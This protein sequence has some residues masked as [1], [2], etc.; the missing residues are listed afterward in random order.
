MTP[1]VLRKKQRNRE[2]EMGGGGGGGG[3]VLFIEFLVRFNR[4][5]EYD[6]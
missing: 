5:D 1:H 3:G 6:V 4:V 2:R